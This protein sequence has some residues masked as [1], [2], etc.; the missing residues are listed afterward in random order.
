[1]PYIE[2]RCV[3]GK[4][5]EIEKYYTSMYKKKGL[6]R[7]QKKEITKEEQK[8]V[9]SRQAEKKL[10]RLLNANFQGGD[11]HLVLDYRKEDRPKSNEELKEHAR[12]YLRELRKEY[13]KLGLELKY[14]HVMEIGSKGAMHHHL[15]I[16]S[17]DTKI[18]ARLWKY[19]R[20]H[21]NLLDE[22]GQY[23]KLASYLMK[24]TDRVRGT[25][26]QIQ[27]KRWNSSRNLIHPEPIKRIITT[28]S[29][30]RE[31]AKDV[32]GYYIDKE[33]IDKRIHEFTGYPY[34]TYT[35]VKMERRRE[36]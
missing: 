19:G 30:Y 2:S 29:W 26:E 4:T 32:K 8:K 9:N 33:T 7:E 14:V 17:I 15:V 24:Y 6:K 27:S 12:K 25:E 10:R 18:L 22:S 23:K 3:A 20:V 21:V 5:V 28:K 16:N 36:T 11:F 13:K 1:M 34:F 31:E 35:L